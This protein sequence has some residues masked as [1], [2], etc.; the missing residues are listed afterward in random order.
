M[1]IVQVQLH[2]NSEHRLI[3]T[4]IAQSSCAKFTHDKVE[5]N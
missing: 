3:V 4:A 2:G 5:P 1:Y